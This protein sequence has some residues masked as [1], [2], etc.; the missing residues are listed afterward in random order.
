M[1]NENIFSVTD[2]TR[3]NKKAS[4]QQED[5]SKKNHLQNSKNGTKSK[6]LTSNE[7]QE[8]NKKDNK[9]VF[10]VS[11][12]ITKHL[13]GYASG[14]KIGNCNVHLRPSHGARVRCVIDHIKPVNGI[15]QIILSF[16]LKLMT[17]HQVKRL[18]ILQ[19]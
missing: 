18:R 14:G 6:R 3:S 10:N 8:A 19:N 15:N 16:M 12:S 17:S 11:D 4:I 1:W 2:E 9:R 13:N 5:R 7:Q